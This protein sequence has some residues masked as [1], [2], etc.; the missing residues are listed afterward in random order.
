MWPFTPRNARPRTPARPRRCAYRP[1]LE[2]LESRDCPS[3]GLLDPTFNGTG[4]QTVAGLTNGSFPGAQSDVVQPADGKVVAV[5]STPSGSGILGA[6]IKVVRL[7]RDG[8]PDTSFN[9]TG[10]VTLSVGY[11]ALGMAIALQPD[12]K[13][14]V[15]GFAAANTLPLSNSEYLVARLNANGTPDASFGNNGVFVYDPI[16]TSILAQQVRCLT[17]Q[18]NGYIL[19]GGV[20]WTSKVHGSSAIAALRLTPS[21]SLDTRF[22]SRGLALVQ[23]PGGSTSGPANAMAVVPTT[24]QVVLAASAGSAAVVVLTSSGGLDTSFNGT[25][26]ELYAGATAFNGV[27]VQQEGSGQYEIVVSGAGSSSSVVGRYFLSGAVDTSFGGAGTGFFAVASGMTINTL[28]LAADGSIIVGGSQTY[29]AT[30]GSQHTEMAVGHLSANGTLD[31][32]FGPNGNGFSYA[33]VGV[34]SSVTALAIDPNDGGIVACG[35]S[36]GTAGFARF[37]AP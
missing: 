10:T 20:G 14:L 30:D 7:N 28:Q 32:S 18:S 5:G 31:T 23:I 12:G 21:G 22:G 11:G 8:S 4:T 15:G 29:T 37:T 13:I 3:G 26:Y 24:G 19:A 34:N 36:D 35:T 2:A 16:T 9:N 1:R 33:M 6:T 17:V 25:G 27:A